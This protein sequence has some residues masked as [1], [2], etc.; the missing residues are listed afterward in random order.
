MPAAEAGLLL[1]L[2]AGLASCG[3][4][5]ELMPDQRLQDE[6]GFSPRDEVHRISITGGEQES[7][8]PR[9]VIVPDDAYVEFVTTDS[10]VHEVRFE[11]DSLQRSARDFLERTDQV[12]SPPMVNADSRFVVFM[13]DAPPGRYPFLVVG[14][15]APTRGAVVVPSDDR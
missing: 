12:A 8:V 10:W 13:E 15:G 11:L 1:I 7:V 9:E 5:P 3:P 2:V 14:N 6:L 4:D